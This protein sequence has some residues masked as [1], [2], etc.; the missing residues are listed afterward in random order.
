[1]T[2]YA[3]LSYFFV[4]LALLCPLMI[5][6]ARGKADG[7][8]TVAA[9]ILIVL[10]QFITPL[11]LTEEILVPELVAVVFFG[12]F[13][14]VL[15]RLALAKRRPG[16]AWT[17]I[18]LALLPLIL[19]KF[20]PSVLPESHFGFAGISY[21]TFRALDVLWAVTD[22]ALKTVGLLDFFVF[23]FFFPTLSSGPIDRFRRFQAQWRQQ[24][25]AEKF[26]QDMDAGVHLVFRGLLYKFIIASLL[27]TYGVEKFGHQHGLHGALL[28][29][30]CY[31]F[32][33]FFDFAGY[34]AFAVGVSRWFGIDTPENFNRPWAAVN[35]REFWNRWHISL[36]VW[37]R[38][39]VY[40]R[41]LLMAVKRKWFK[42]RIT[43]ATLGYFVSF[44]LMGIW[45]GKE[46]Y[47]I[48]Y[49]LYHAVLMSV[50]DAFTRWKKSHPGSFIGTRWKWAA[51]FLTIH[52]V[53]FGLWLFSGHGWHP[54]SD[55]DAEEVVN[56]DMR[57]Q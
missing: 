29:A 8:W 42:S 19:A 35:I 34:S 9:T 40:S 10:L 4:L 52:A 13:Q 7:R 36:S 5:A 6:G 48:A 49:G 31:S 20:L 3:N 28:Y 47:Y 32:Y 44:G 45:H 22:G 23:M 56:A 33:L 27:N 53:I 14:W 37:F 15:V 25:T 21:V 30:Y 46:W 16:I 1:M 2:P 43:P 57:K 24:R 38:D 41:F 54:D 12:V 17:L 55:P 18:P 39:H 50:F 26:W 11:H 51:H